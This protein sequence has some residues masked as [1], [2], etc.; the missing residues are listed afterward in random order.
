MANDPRY[1]SADWKKVRAYVLQRDRYQCRMVPDCPIRATHVD[2]IVS[3]KL[4]GDFYALGNLRSACA[5]HNKSAGA[6]FVN[7]R[8]AEADRIV[9][10]GFRPVAAQRPAR[11]GPRT[12]YDGSPRGADETYC[13]HGGRKL[14]E[15]EVCPKCNRRGW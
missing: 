9:Q 1:S 6:A 10:G 3:P 11:R 5:R 8:R 13:T 4:G 15:G 2:H 12:W 14:A 7:R